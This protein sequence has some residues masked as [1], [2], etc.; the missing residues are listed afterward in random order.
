MIKQKIIQ[1]TVMF[2]FLLMPFLTA[3]AQ[4]DEF[5]DLFDDDVQDVPAAP[6]DKYIL[7]AVV[8]AIY[9]AYR[10]LKAQQTNNKL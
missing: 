6:I 9:M 10:F 8:I 7:I 4:D 3:M 2:F 1:K 5:D